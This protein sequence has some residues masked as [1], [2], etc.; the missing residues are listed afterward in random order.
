M[1]RDTVKMAETLADTSVS[2]AKAT[3]SA[4]TITVANGATVPGFFSVKDNSG[5]VVVDASTAGNVIFKAGDAYPSQNVLGD[6]SVAVVVGLNVIQVERHGRFENKDGS[7]NI[8]FGGEVAGKIYAFG[9]HAGL[10]PVE[11]QD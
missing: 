9:K 4:T 10:A 8:D 1:A 11:H 7:L 2:V 6:L 3:A 5:F